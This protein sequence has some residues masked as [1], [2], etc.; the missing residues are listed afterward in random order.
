MIVMRK[1][2]TIAGLKLTFIEKQNWRWGNQ[3]GTL[4]SW[5]EFEQCS[6][7]E[8]KKKNFT[9]CVNDFDLTPTPKQCVTFV[10]LLY[11]SMQG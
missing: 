1:F 7:A 10:A 4:L 5:N 6:A 2:D 11:M 9:A 8:E 3:I